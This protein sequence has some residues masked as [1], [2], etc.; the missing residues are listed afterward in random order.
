LCPRSGL[1][2]PARYTQCVLTP[3][4]KAAEQAAADEQED[5]PSTLIDDDA[6][7]PDAGKAAAAATRKTQAQ[8][9]RQLAQDR[10]TVSNELGLGLSNYYPEEFANKYCET[11]PRA[12]RNMKSGFVCAP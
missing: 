9:R 1:A 12:L 2:L 11:D 4:E 8:M 5:D 7:L 6:V 3:K 10:M